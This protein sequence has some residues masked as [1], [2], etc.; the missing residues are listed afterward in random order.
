MDVDIAQN[1]TRGPNGIN[2]E[3]PEVSEQPVRVAKRVGR[4][5]FWLLV[6]FFALAITQFGILGLITRLG[7]VEEVGIWN[8]AN[9][10][11]DPFLA[12]M[13]FGTTALLMAEIARRRDES[14][15][16]LGNGLTLGLLIG[17][18]VLLVMML[19]AN[20]DFLKLSPLMIHAIYLTGISS[21][22]FTTAASFRSAFRAFNQLQYEAITSIAM[23]VFAIISAFVILYYGFPFLW[24]FVA[25]VFS[26]VIALVGSWWFYNRRLGRLKVAYNPLIFRQ[27]LNKTWAFIMVGLL[28]RAFSRVD[29]LIL[30]FFHGERAAGYYGLATVLFYQLNTIAQLFTTAILPTMAS[31]Y[32]KNRDRVGNQLDATVRLQILVGL[33]C[34]AIGVILAPQIIRFLYGPGYE[35]TAYIFQLLVMV[36]VLRFVNQTLG[37]VLTAMDQQGRRAITLTL[38]V[39]FNLGANFAL[40]PRWGMLGATLTS[41]LAE[42]VLFIL[43]YAF[44]AAEVRQKIKWSTLIR[45]FLSTLILAPLLYVIRDWP[46]LFSLSMGLVI[47]LPLLFLCRTFSAEETKALVQMV[48]RIRPIPLSIRRTLSAFMLRHARG[49]APVAWQTVPI[50]YR[51]DNDDTDAQ[52]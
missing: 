40:I 14:D 46:L 36:V 25:M 19:V 47:F 3:A 32:V 12:F 6:S 22:I 8:Y 10:F 29:I 31:S 9:A 1:A 42:V 39:L 26:R 21:L 48:N 51:G 28:S 20:L 17:L 44:I 13:D 37:I 2:K 24:L 27:L 11:R 5:A 50:H 16:L 34:T 43:T 38:T 33:P 30:G 35:N 4:N 41:M 49:Q 15:A 18:P 45:P 52:V 7:G 23:M